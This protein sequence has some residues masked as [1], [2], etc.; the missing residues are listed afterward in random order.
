MFFDRP[1]IGIDV[2]SSAVKIVELA[3]NNRKQLRSVG[4]ELLPAGTV[5][6]GNIKKE[7][8]LINTVRDLLR[9]LKISTSGRRAAISLAGNAVIIK[10]LRVPRTNGGLSDE[11]IYVAAE[12]HFQ[13]DMSELY[14]R[15]HE[16][17]RARG[18]TDTAVICVG[19][20]RETVEQYI[21]FVR[22]LGMRTGVVDCDCFSVYNMF[23]H[24]Y[25]E[26]EQLVALVNIG[27]SS[28][29]VSLISKGQYLFSRD[30]ALGGEHYTQRIAE[31]L[32]VDRENAE[33]LKIGASDVE[34][35]APEQL[36]KLVS[37]INSQLID[38]I[39]TTVDY[40][41][42]SGDAPPELQRVEYI[43]LSGGGAKIADLDAALSAR[44]QLPVQIM[45]PFHRIQI[46][47]NR[48][49]SDYLL[50][51]GHLYGVAV[52]LA[53]REFKDTSF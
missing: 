6:E 3:G 37:E 17:E 27:A 32:K 10:R 50:N 45:N 20:R 33:T 16:D 18:E 51:Q 42:S 31:E 28:T 12:Q 23:E 14:F 44:M 53:M 39:K 35:R 43:F 1:L 30:I 41:F 36:S 24:N 40:F 13:Y 19:A 8:D 29:Q 22:S 49:R 52:G 11:E 15:Y 34:G 2:G 7:S 5:A 46:N 47:P 4:L 48:F 38:E 9:K 21:A 25:G 26:V